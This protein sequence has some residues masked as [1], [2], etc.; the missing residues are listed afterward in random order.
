MNRFFAICA[1][2]TLSLAAGFAYAQ[3]H[4]RAAHT[5][6]ATGSSTVTAAMSAGEVKK[7]DKA[8]GKITIQHGPLLNLNMPG[9]TMAFKVQNPVMLDQ[10]K[11]GDK[12]NFVADHVN[13]AFTVTKLEAAR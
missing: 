10:V 13:G 4:D 9:M 7:I 3:A 12:I 8:A 2:A 1:S 6:A 5:A 11:A